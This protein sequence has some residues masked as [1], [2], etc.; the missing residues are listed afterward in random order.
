MTTPA[1]STAT[2]NRFEPFSEDEQRLMLEALNHY[3]GVK[4][5]AFNIAKTLPMFASIQPR[6]FGID[7]LDRL[8]AEAN[9]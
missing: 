8:I 2:V 7:I 3:H 4:T 1:P 5:E 6:D 9:Q